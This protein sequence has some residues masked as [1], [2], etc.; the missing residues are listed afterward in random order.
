M[1]PAALQLPPAGRQSP[2]R[3]A[4]MAHVGNMFAMLDDESEDPQQL[5][6]AAAKA[7]KAAAA[8]Q[9][10][11]PEAPAKPAGAQ[12][13]AHA[14]V[15]RGAAAL[16]GAAVTG[17]IQPRTQGQ[18]GPTARAMAAAAVAGPSA[19]AGATAGGAGPALP[20]RT[21]PWRMPATCPPWATTLAAP[22]AAAVGAV[23]GAGAR[24]AGAGATTSATTAR[25]G[26]EGRMGPACTPRMAPQP[27]Q[28][29]SPPRGHRWP[30][31]GRA[32]SRSPHTACLHAC[33]RAAA[34][35]WCPSAANNWRHPNA[36][37][38]EVEKRGGAGKGNWGTAEDEIQEAAKEAK[39]EP[40]G[41]EAPAAEAEAVAAA[42]P[43]EPKEE[44]KPVRGAGRSIAAGAAGAGA[45]AHA[46]VHARAAHAPVLPSLPC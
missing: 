20:A 44:E 16:A 1:S 5:A 26:G 11:Q 22:A 17:S 4:G 42:E 2:H 36:R 13:L 23:A 10:Q 32:A 18:P 40:F 29:C 8:K 46:C 43:A 21:A 35:S 14:C 39:E 34:R 6:R 37:S 28:H 15:Q 41:G 7:E 45:G 27:P 38:H 31:G 19:A 25:A 12:G 9:A 3:T 33:M 24:A 30:R